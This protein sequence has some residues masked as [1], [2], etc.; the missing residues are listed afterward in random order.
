MA[1][2][3]TTRAGFR[4]AREPAHRPPSPR[5]ELRMRTCGTSRTRAADD[6]RCSTTSPGPFCSYAPAADRTSPAC[7]AAHTR[8]SVPARRKQAR[9]RT[10]PHSVGA[11]CTAER[12]AHDCRPGTIPVPTPTGT[13]PCAHSSAP[14]MAPTCGCV[15]WGVGN[16]RGCNSCG[17]R[18]RGRR[19][20]PGQGYCPCGVGNGAGH[21]VALLRG[22]RRSSEN[23][24]DAGVG[25]T[26]CSFRPARCRTRLWSRSS[27]GARPAEQS[28]SARTFGDGLTFAP[29]ARTIRLASVQ[30]SGGGRRDSSIRDAGRPERGRCA[31]GLCRQTGGL[32]QLSGVV[33]AT[34]PTFLHVSR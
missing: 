8:S 30:A 11:R 7:G 14:S 26:H 18:G 9:A 10:R 27:Q 15:V 23:G 21:V 12:D 5:A 25:R 22:G 29:E 24:L 13:C 1:Q 31:A 33:H 6:M 32:P 2:P 28:D 20:A 16:V 19:S 34:R 4:H 3:S 17:S